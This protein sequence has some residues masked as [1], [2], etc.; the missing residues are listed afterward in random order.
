M[1]VGGFSA[2]GGL[3][4]AGVGVGVGGR[5]VAVGW[6]GV[7]STWE[8]VTVKPGGRFGVGPSVPGGWVGVAVGVVVGVS[9]AVAGSTRT[10]TAITT[11]PA[12]LITGSGGW[13]SRDHMDQPKPARISSTPIIN[14]PRERAGRNLV[15]S[16]ILSQRQSLVKLNCPMV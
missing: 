8:G 3:V 16:V 13:F 12:S 4:G 11:A 6:V 15:M 14:I 2:G 10:V 5:G 9:V 1:R 7:A